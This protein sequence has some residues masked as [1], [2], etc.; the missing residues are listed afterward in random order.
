LAIGAFHY[1]ADLLQQSREQRVLR[2]RQREERPMQQCRICGL[3][4]RGSRQDARFCSPAC[5]QKAYR[6]RQA[7]PEL[8]TPH[9][10]DP[11]PDDA[12][13]LTEAAGSLLLNARLAG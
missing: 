6:H 9:R 11:T 3:A 13:W 10:F 8:A 1:F 7:E 5:R 12:L 4:F 2:R